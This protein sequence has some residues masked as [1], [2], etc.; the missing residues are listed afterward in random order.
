MRPVGEGYSPLR[1][2]ASI[3]W[4]P[5]I[6]RANGI[7]AMLAFALDAG[8]DENTD[9]LTVAGFAS[10][11]VHWDDFTIKWKSRLDRDGIEFFRA[12]DANSFRGPF[13]HWFNR[14]DRIQ[15]REKLFADLMELIQSHAYWKV[16]A[17]IVNRDFRISNSEMRQR[18]VESAYS[19]AARTCEKY[20]RHWL[21]KD[22]K[23]CPNTEA[24]FILEAGDR[25]QSKLQE[26]L[27][28]DYGQIPPNFRPKKDTLRDDGV[29]EYGFIPLQAADW[30]AWEMNRATRDSYAQK[31]EDES[32]L[33]WPM[34]QFLRKPIGY[35]GFYALEDLQRMDDMITLESEI[36]SW[37]N[38]LGLKKNDAST[39]GK[40]AQ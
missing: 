6:D 37:E 26:R 8:G 32:Q 17:T 7:F 30:F 31:L 39:K 34:Q 27:R 12:V 1:H 36:V 10:S 5:W 13:Q 2:L 15:L 33:R 23:S 4:P 16:A 25:G 22:W 19:L 28:K 21:L 11:T 38:Q 3:I 40:T 29:M 24:A 20:G 9:F 35:L 18:F 14:T